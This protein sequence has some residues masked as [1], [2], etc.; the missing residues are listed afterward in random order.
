MVVILAPSNPP[1]EIE[2]E[3]TASS[4]TWTVHAPH[5]AMPQPYLVPV[6]P[7]SSRKTQSNGVS[8]SISSSCRRPFTLSV[9]IASLLYRALCQSCRSVFRNFRGVA[10]VNTDRRA[11]RMAIA[12]RVQ[13]GPGTKR[14]LKC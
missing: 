14:P 2:Q 7:I 9:I 12:D 11:W 6:M 5:W 10:E 4:F 1:T 8:G 3:R 13:A